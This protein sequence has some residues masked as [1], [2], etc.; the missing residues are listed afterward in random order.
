[1]TTRKLGKHP[2][3]PENWTGLRLARHLVGTPIAAKSINWYEKVTALPIYMNDSIGDC[4]LAAPGHSTGVW[5][6]NTTKEIILPDSA[7][8]AAYRA[9]GGYVPGRPDTD[10]G[11]NMQDVL[12]YWRLHGIGGYKILNSAQIDIKFINLVKLA[13]QWFGSIYIGVNLPA[14]LQDFTGVWDRPSNLAGDNAPGTWGGHAIEI[15]AY[16]ANTATCSTW[17]A[18]QQMTWSWFS[19]Y[20][21][22]GYAPFSL[23]WI[24]GAKAPNGLDVLSLNSNLSVVA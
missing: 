3:T 17:G 22:E 1:M 21:D 8:L 6:A 4:A 12:A 11:S 23:D 16:D 15:S 2:A 14:Y 7:I 20:A 19:A 24:F 13:I 10:N 9:V 18:K 5:T